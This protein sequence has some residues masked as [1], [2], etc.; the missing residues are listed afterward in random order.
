MSLNDGA[1]SQDVYDRLSDTREQVEREQS[2]GIDYGM[3][4]KGYQEVVNTAVETEIF[5]D[6][7]E[8]G[9]LGTHGFL[10]FRT[11]AHPINTTGGARNVIIRVYLGATNIFTD[12]IAIG[13]QGGAFGAFIIWEVWIGNTGVDNVQQCAYRVMN[14]DRVVPDTPTNWNF[15]Q[16]S[17]NVAAENT[18]NDLI[19][20]ATVQL[21]VA[22]ARV[23][24]RQTGAQM[25]GP[26]Y[27]NI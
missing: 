2:L 22:D 9:E 21:S 13:A 8:G 18:A 16:G 10:R 1:L 11:C 27:A 7:I 5:T 19:F 25:W 26:Y 3:V 4:L 24:Y 23:A 14:L 15:D 12:T 6:T 20:R 17:W